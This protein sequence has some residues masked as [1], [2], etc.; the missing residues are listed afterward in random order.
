MS[1][2]YW[3]EQCR[4]WSGECETAIRGPL[5]HLWSVRFFLEEFE[6]DT[7]ILG[8]L[9]VGAEVTYD[10]GWAPYVQGTMTIVRPAAALLAALDPRKRI[11]VELSAGYVLPGARRDVHP[12]CAAYLSSRDVNHPADTVTLGFQGKEYLYRDWRAGTVDASPIPPGGWTSTTPADVAVRACTAEM[13][14]GTGLMRDQK[15]GDNMITDV[16]WVDAADPWIGQAGDEPLTMAYEIASRVAGWFY[17]DEAG[18]WQLRRI[19]EISIGARYHGVRPGA[20]GT[21]ITAAD[22]LT[23]DGWAN[24]VQVTYR[25]STRAPA[26]GTG[27]VTEHVATGFATVADGPYHESL[28][29]RVTYLSDRT[30][31]GTVAQAQTAARNLL[32]RMLDRGTDV[33]VES[34]AAYWIRVGDLIGLDLPGQGQRTLAVQAVTYRLDTGL[35]DIRA[36]LPELGERAV[37]GLGPP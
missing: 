34:V 13:A 14:F 11:R 1:D 36:R 24:Y 16:G 28:S 26:T 25:W 20:D 15:F 10:A 33:Q 18:V 7:E 37:I 35:M 9:P 23:R 27:T 6:D 12:M 32:R 4:P 19:D 22:G 3:D 8:V 2:E 29:N 21:L 31:P 5:E 30:T 17:A